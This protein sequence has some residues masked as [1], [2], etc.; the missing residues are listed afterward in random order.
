[1]DGHNLEDLEE[2]LQ[3]AKAYEC[4]VFVHIHTKKG[5][6]YLPSEKNPDEFHGISRFNVETGNPEI[7]GKDTYSDI[8][9][10]ELVRLAKKDASICAITAAMEPGCNIFPEPIRSGIMMLAL[11]NSMRLRLQLHWHR[12]ESYL[13]LQCILLSCSVPMTSCCMMLRLESSTL[14]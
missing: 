11:R 4:P 13:F 2:V 7:S 5:K 8:F 9:G 1:M 12:R 6:G 3:A 14:S 10:K